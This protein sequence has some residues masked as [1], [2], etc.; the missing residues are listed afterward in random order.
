MQTAVDGWELN[1]GGNV[2][3]RVGCQYCGRVVTVRNM[4]RDLR[5]SCRVWDP[6]GGRPRFA[7]CA[8]KELKV[9]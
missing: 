6:R 9:S 7:V 1:V 3:G 8:R 4:A 2:G 5:Q